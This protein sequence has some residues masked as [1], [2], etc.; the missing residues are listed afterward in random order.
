MYFDLSEGPASAQSRSLGF[1]L[2]YLA[3]DLPAMGK[4]SEEVSKTVKTVM[5]NT[6]IKIGVVLLMKRLG[7]ITKN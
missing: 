6:I 2:A 7:I 4:L 1:C 3:Q 5:A